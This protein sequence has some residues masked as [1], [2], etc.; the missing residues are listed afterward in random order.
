MKWKILL[1]FI[2]CSLLLSAQDF[3]LDKRWKGIDGGYSRSII[4][5]SIPASPPIYIFMITSD[6]DTMFTSGGDTMKVKQALIEFNNYNNGDR[7]EKDILFNSHV[8]VVLF[9]RK[10]TMAV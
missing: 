5:P 7:N 1:L 4:V 10:C 3:S 2:M 6:G 9:E 8:Y